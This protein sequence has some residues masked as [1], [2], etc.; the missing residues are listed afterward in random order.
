[1]EYGL[2]GGA[3]LGVVVNGVAITPGSTIAT[4]TLNGLSSCARHSLSPSNAHFEAAY[5]PCGDIP[6]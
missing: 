1:M 2:G 6:N 3:G 5:G 4:L